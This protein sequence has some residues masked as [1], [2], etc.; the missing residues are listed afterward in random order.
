MFVRISA[1]LERQDYPITAERHGCNGMRITETNNE[2]TITI[3]IIK[4][5]DEFIKSEDFRGRHDLLK[6]SVK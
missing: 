4:I 6:Q 5:K 1:Q 2:F 3:F